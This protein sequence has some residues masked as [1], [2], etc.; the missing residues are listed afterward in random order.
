[1]M[2][3]QEIEK[4]LQ[5]LQGK[6]PTIIIKELQDKLVSKMDIL[7][8]EQVDLIIDEV[9]ENYSGQVERLSLIHI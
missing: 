7:T 3:E 4:K 5:R 1:M 2:L 8:P 6:V 9:L